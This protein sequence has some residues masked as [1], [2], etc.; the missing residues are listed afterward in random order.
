[1]CIYTRPQSVYM[2]YLL[3]CVDNQE[4]YMEC[5]DNT[6]TIVEDTPI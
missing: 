2:P 5:I 1:M 6:T 3:V 4:F